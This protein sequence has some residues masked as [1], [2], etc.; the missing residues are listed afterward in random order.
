[1]QGHTN[2]ASLNKRISATSEPDLNQ[3][4]M[5]AGPTTSTL[6]VEEDGKSAAQPGA[7]SR[8]A[9]ADTLPLRMHLLLRTAA[10][11][12]RQ[13][14]L[15]HMVAKVPL[16]VAEPALICLWCADSK[17][18]AAMPNGAG[19]QALAGPPA[20]PAARATAAEIAAAMR[21]V[22]SAVVHNPEVSCCSHIQAARTNAIILA[23]LLPWPAAEVQLPCIT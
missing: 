6:L 18:P 8:T 13:A 12:G 10:P 22:A 7:L 5:L 16:A 17:A 15:M 4:R 9:W 20:A 3:L 23:E 2:I 19:Q 1:M 14:L 11:L 21:A